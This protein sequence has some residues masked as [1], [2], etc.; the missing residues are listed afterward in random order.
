MKKLILVGGLWLVLGGWARAQQHIY[1]PFPDTLAMWVDQY[2][3]TC[4]DQVT[5]VGG[6]MEQCDIFL[7]EGDTLLSDSS[8]WK[9]LWLYSS[10][11]QTA[12]KVFFGGLYED[13]TKKIWL[14]KADS[15]PP[16]VLYDFAL[17][18]GD[19][20][21]L[22]IPDMDTMYAIVAQDVVDTL[23]G[24]D[25]RK[26]FLNFA[27]NG[28]YYT[29][30]GKPNLFLAQYVTWLEGIGADK[31]FIYFLDYISDRTCWFD[32]SLL[33]Y[34]I[35]T[36]NFSL[37]P[38]VSCFDYVSAPTIVS[39]LAFSLTPNPASSYLTVSISEQHTGSTLTLTDLAGR[40]VLKSEIENSQSETS[41]A[42]LP[43]GIYL[44]VL[45]TPSGQQAVR[46]VV[47]E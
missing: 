8:V 26:L 43:S 42:A 46:K 31:G 41:I 38:S 45:T 27:Q 5:G 21:W 3:Q 17:T 13:S 39:P 9:K 4:Y 47:K 14:K 7:M 10:T 30:N 12:Q 32:K 25:L 40:V 11:S 24:K 33:Y 28:L 44:A 34:K 23:N 20:F 16:F 1:H 15:T 35:D 22:Q 6:H 37:S 2:Q 29:G 18:V 36:V 19:T